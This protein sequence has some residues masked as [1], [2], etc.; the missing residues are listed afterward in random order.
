[1]I[2]SFHL[3]LSHILWGVVNCSDHEISV[4]IRYNIEQPSGLLNLRDLT[5]ERDNTYL[6]RHEEVQH[7]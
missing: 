1:M 7:A 4:R 6:E 2:I 3:L 5:S